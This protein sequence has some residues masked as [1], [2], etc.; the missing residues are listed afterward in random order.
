VGSATGFVNELR[1]CTGNFQKGKNLERPSG[2][3]GIER[4]SAI[5]LKIIES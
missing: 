3:P 5:L 2:V 4:Q 1:K